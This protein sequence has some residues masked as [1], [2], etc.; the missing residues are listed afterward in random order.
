MPVGYC[1]PVL[2]AHDVA[3]DGPAVILLHSSVCDRRMWDPQWQML[4]DA[5]YRLVRC[6]FRGH[7]DSPAPAG[8]FNA[9][10]DVRDL[11]DALQV[12]NAIVIGSSYG[13]RV[14]QEIAARWPS[15]VTALLLLCAATRLHPPTE[16][17]M[18]FGAREQELLD[19]GDI[20]AAVAL[21]VT[22]FLGPAASADT[23]AA[24]AAMQR[25]TFDIQMAA[26]DAAQTRYSGHARNCD[27]DLSAITARTVVVSGG[28]D[29][30]YFR[31]TADHLAESIPG[32]TRVDL[33]WAGHLPTLEDP[34]TMNPL[35]LSWLHPDPPGPRR[36]ADPPLESYSSP[37]PRVA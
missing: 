1:R 23:R 28:L 15:R 34:V 27:F 17:I 14:A 37:T 26:D 20:E 7:G 35:I 2:L 4:L 33:A 3:G 13:G 18:T 11:L 6:D 10:E 16:A 25:S 36:R 21:N 9:A 19:A 32:A 12:P 24:V 29:V 5:G 31:S 8:P 30:D 22:T